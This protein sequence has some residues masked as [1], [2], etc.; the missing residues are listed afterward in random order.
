MLSRMADVVVTVVV[1]RVTVTACDILRNEFGPVK[2]QK[3]N[4]TLGN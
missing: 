3:T 1:V 2:K 4:E